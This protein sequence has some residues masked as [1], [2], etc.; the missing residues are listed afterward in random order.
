MS[1]VYSDAE[2]LEQL[3]PFEHAMSESVKRGERF[4]PEGFWTAAVNP[5][6]ASLNGPEFLTALSIAS[7]MRTANDQPTREQIDARAQTLSILL[8][9]TNEIGWGKAYRLMSQSKTT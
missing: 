5:E 4:N 3:R 7:L 9:V 6:N 8:H 2:Y 1:K